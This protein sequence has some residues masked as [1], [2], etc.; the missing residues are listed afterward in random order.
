[1]IRPIL[2]FCAL[3]WMGLFLGVVLWLGF[4]YGAELRTF[5][6]APGEINPA[7]TQDNIETT[8]CVP[9]WT[10]TVRPPVS[11]T[12]KLKA[13]LLGVPLRVRPPTRGHSSRKAKLRTNPKLKPYE[14]D[15]KVA[16]TNGGHPRSRKNLWLQPWEG[17]CN[18]RQ[19]DHV[20]INA[21]KK[22]CSGEMTLVEGQAA[23]M[24]W[25]EY[26]RNYIDPKGCE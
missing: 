23:Q 2:I 13:E 4:A 5:E 18:A 6:E 3:V 16:L 22:I 17:K 1:M 24:D 26:Y 12:N 15:H 9:G 25:K 11:Y 7:V 14:L 20:E 10:K 19:K 8:I 21:N